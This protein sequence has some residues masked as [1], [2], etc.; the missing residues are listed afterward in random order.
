M[1]GIRVN[2]HMHSNIPGLLA[3]GEAVGGAGGA[4]RLSGN[5]ITEALVFGEIAGRSAAAT[6][7]Q[8][9]RQPTPTRFD[10]HDASKPQ[11][12]STLSR[13][14]TLRDLMWSN[15]GP[16]RTHTG[17][18]EALRWIHQERAA[19]DGTTPPLPTPFSNELAVWHDFRH[20][21]LVADAVAT[22][23]IAR[24]E[25]RGAH[26]RDDYPETDSAHAHNATV[27]FTDGAIQL[28]TVT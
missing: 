5:A 23:A 16:F 20:G 25:S 24:Q 28:A 10:D 12:K 8:N 27:T 22:A 18:Q 6:A 15:V 7:V 9:R 11:A 4:N 3:A 17:L 21:L 26:Q 2:K 14:R 13:I 1:G 19:H